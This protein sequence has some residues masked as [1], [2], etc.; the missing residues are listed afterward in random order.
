MSW[1]SKNTYKDYML[2]NGFSIKSVGNNSL[3]LNNINKIG[4]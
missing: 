2:N 1:V 3:A 4:G